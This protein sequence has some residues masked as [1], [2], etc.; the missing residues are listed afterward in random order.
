M[1]LLI[2]RLLIFLLIIALSACAVP[3]SNIGTVLDNTTKGWG[4]KRAVP[5]PEFTEAQME[6]M[7]KYDCYYLGSDKEKNLYLTFDEGYENGYT[8][9]IL[10]VLKEK[11]VPAAFFVT[12]PYLRREE[13]LVQR[14]L[15]EGHIVGNHSINHP[16]LPELNRE[17]IENELYGLDLMF[18]ERYGKHMKYLRPPRGEYSTAT[19]DITTDMGYTNVFWSLA[20]VDWKTDQQK[21][22]DYAIESVIPQLHNGA[23]IL[24]HAVS[25]DNAAAMGEIIDRAR[26]EGYTFKSLDEYN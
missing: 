19:L 4:L 15:D 9:K 20:Y 7:N 14:M 1:H 8:D 12:G 11:K 17:Q 3:V 2:K 21:G 24:L 26:E 22:K 18:Y 23:V 25:A 10:D 16:S 6:E 5:R 13:K